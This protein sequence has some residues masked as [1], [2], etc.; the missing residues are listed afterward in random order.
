MSFATPNRRNISAG[1]LI[2]GFGLAQSARAASDNAPM[3]RT[4]S[5][6]EIVRSHAGIHQEVTFA[7]SASRVY[8]LLTAAEQF[9]RVVRLS[10]AMNSSMRASLG[11]KGTE[12]EARPGGAFALYGG[13]I[14][15]Y[16]LELVP[17]TR[18]VQAW[19]SGSWEPGLF[20]IAHFV[21]AEREGSTTLIFDHT[22]FPDD[23]ASHLALGW[24]AN[25]WEPMAKAL[26]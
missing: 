26:G 4:D 8:N 19:R 2:A 25:Y 11:T 20:S 17:A 18:L 6:G 16:N 9:D 7:A 3:V 13:Y 12:I 15:G 5:A 14:T 22:G 24:R 21:F 10:G 1:L 23:A